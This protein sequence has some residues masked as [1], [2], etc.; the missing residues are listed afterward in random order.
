[1]KSTADKLGD[2]N[3]ADFP[4]Y[5]NKKKKHKKLQPPAWNDDCVC[6]YFSG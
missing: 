1:M 4:V 3:S 2:K 5:I 6:I